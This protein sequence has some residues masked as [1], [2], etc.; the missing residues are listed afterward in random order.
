M[1]DNHGASLARLVRFGRDSQAA[2]TLP[3]VPSF[4]IELFG[5]V[6]QL[7]VAIQ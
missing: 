3:P 4:F 5:T 7:C 2:L 1:N 6:D